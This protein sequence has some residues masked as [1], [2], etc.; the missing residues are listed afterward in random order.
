MQLEGRVHDKQGF[1]AGKY[2]KANGFSSGMPYW[3]QSNGTNALWFASGKWRISI[4]KEL[5]TGRGYL[6]STNSPICPESVGSH[7][8]YTNNGEWLNAQENATMYKYEGTICQG[9]KKFIKGK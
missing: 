6:Y 8:K 9:N 2:T 4:K 7:W 3:I 1:R 5:G